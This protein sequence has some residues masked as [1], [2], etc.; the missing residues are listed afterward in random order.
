MNGIDGSGSDD[1]FASDSSVSASGRS[2]SSD[3]GGG[4]SGSGSGRSGSGSGRS[5]S[6]DDGG[7]GR[8]GSSDDGCPPHSSESDPDPD[9]GP[10]AGAH[11][12]TFIR[13][14]KFISARVWGCCA[15]GAAWHRSRA[16]PDPT[17]QGLPLRRCRTYEPEIFLKGGRVRQTSLHL[18]R[19]ANCSRTDCRDGANGPSVGA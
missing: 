2:G 5:G 11:P 13:S 1:G 18:R 19:L 15:E 17:S 8:S 7:G 6:S 3:D 14:K 9:P 16:T 12:P 4:R 10:G